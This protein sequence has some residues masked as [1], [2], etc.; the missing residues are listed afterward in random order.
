VHKLILLVVV[1]EVAA[2]FGLRIRLV[3]M[4]AVLD[5]ASKPGLVAKLVLAVVVAVVSSKLGLLIRFV[6]A[7]DDH[8]TPAEA[9]AGLVTSRHVL[10]KKPSVV[11]RTNEVPLP[12]ADHPVV[13]VLNDGLPIRFIRLIR[14][15]LYA[16][17]VEA[18]DRLQQQVQRCPFQDSS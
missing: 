5:D 11:L 12:R 8:A 16:F 14:E 13:S 1:V 6:V 10:P 4:V 18:H 9:I 2:K 15:L 3:R 7:A 17:E